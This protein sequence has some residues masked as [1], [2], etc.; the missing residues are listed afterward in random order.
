M[1]A[2]WCE[3]DYQIDI[4]TPEGREEYKRIIDRSAELGLDYI[5]YAPTNSLLGDRSETADDWNWENL[6]WLGLGIKIRKG[7]WDPKKDPIP[8]TVQQMLDYAKSKKIKLVAYMYPVMPFSGNPEWIVEGTKYHRKKR[9]ASLGVR[10][11]QDYLI[12]N[13][14]AFHE[15][16]GLGGY[17]YDYT[18]LWYDNTSFYAQWWGWRRIKETLRH[19]YPDIVIDGRQLDMLYGP[20]IWL[21][22][23]YPHP[24]AADEQPESFN[25]FPDL[26]FDRASANRQ[27]F[28]AYRYRVNDYCPPELMPGFITHQTSRK[29][30]D[31]PIKTSQGGKKG[32]V[33]LRLDSFRTRDWD[34]LGWKYSLISSIATA[35]FNHVVSMIPARDIEEFKHFSEADKKF[36][37]DWLDWTDKNSPYLSKTRPIIGQPT[38][39]LIDGTSAII[40]DNG[41]IFL[42]NPNARKMDAEFYLDQSIGLM[43]GERFTISELYPVEGK[44]IG[45]PGFG[46]WSYSDKVTISMDGASALVLKIDPVSNLLKKPM[47]FN[48]KGNVEFEGNSLILTNVSG[49]TGTLIEALVLTAGD[50]PV[51]AVEV[52]QKK[53]NFYKNK[54]LISLDLK[55]SGSYFPQLKQIGK[56]SSDFYGGTLKETFKIPGR[57]FSQLEERKKQW[58]LPWTKEDYKT[59]WLVPER[60]LLFVQIAEVKEE[61]EIQLSINGE[62][63]ELNKAYTSIRR[64]PRCFVGF[65]AD[66][67][68]LKPDEEY[69]AELILP[70]LKPGQFQG[71]FFENIETEYSSDIH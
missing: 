31:T 52:N 34:Y 45:K 69:Q 8:E 65:Y 2:A 26:H 15:R 23:S 41:Y 22:G 13:L 27:R 67:S 5:L 44:L 56:Y 18:F 70:D 10:S 38:I 32:K 58:P 48:V 46:L 36:F 29:E 9:N 59:T 21:S 53:I 49:E 62:P 51:E 20:W 68:H 30:G 57:V 6:L 40:N 4:A 28:T 64:H 14:S 24:T 50:Q 71:L 60:L 33:R 42:F 35:G 61:M 54:N 55:F 66:V 1:N 37:R 11:F 47:L 39:G 25:P 17:A 43:S 12:E 63:I 3:N 16:T 19:K 7:E